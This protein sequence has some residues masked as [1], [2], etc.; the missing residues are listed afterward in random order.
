M[1][2][3]IRPKDDTIHIMNYI[4]NS[5]VTDIVTIDIDGSPNTILFRYIGA[6]TP[7]VHDINKDANYTKSNLEKLFLVHTKFDLE[8]RCSEPIDELKLTKI[9]EIINRFNLDEEGHFT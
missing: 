2:T 7:F 3:I 6:W 1:R 9:D 5:E 4:N 8:F